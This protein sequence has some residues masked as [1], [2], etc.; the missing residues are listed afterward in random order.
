VNIYLVCN[1]P[2]L[3][4]L[5]SL[6][7]LT[8]LRH[9]L[10]TIYGSPLPFTPTTC[11]HPTFPSEYNLHSAGIYYS[12]PTTVH[13]LIYAPPLRE[14]YQYL[15]QPSNLAHDWTKFAYT[16]GSKKGGA[17]PLGAAATHPSS[18]THL[19]IRVSST[20]QTRTI[21]RAELAAIDLGLKLGH[22][23]LPTDS[24]CALRLIHKYLRCPHSM[25][26][27]V[28]MDVLSSILSTLQ[29]RSKA[30]LHTHLGKIKAHN[31]SKG[32]DLADHLAN[33]VADGYNSDVIYFK[34]SHTQ[35]GLWTWPYTTH[36]D[37]PN[38]PKTLTYTTL[39]CDA[40]KYSLTHTIPPSNTPLNTA[41]Y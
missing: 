27:H 16:Y 35:I 26:Q 38:P 9:T 28:H 3:T 4:Y 25:R 22:T 21:N 39:K 32:N 8:S 2:A 23:A 31:N 40:K 36:P 19:R 6:E 41:S 18:D 14:S 13:P 10:E 30:G 34:G 5:P 17:T 7:T 15:P 20:P 29:T 33:T 1:T 37:D 12:L 11:T 24:A